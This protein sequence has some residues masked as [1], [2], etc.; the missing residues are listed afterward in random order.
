MPLVK[1]QIEVRPLLVLAQMGISI[2]GL[3]IAW[4]AQLPARIAL[5]RQPI[6]LL[7]METAD[8]HQLVG[9]KMVF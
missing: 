5:D 8:R 3:P 2:T 9:A 4:L 7:A 1:E 6:V